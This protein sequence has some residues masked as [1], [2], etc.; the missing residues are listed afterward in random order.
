MLGAGGGLGIT[1]I[2]VGKAM[3]AKVIA[4]ASSQDK[5]D[6]CIKEGADEGILYSR[7]MD[8]DLQK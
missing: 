1:A 7:E 4:A 3:G 5:L 6:L 8:R 2:H